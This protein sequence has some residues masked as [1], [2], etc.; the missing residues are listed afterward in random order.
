YTELP[1]AVQHVDAPENGDT[2][3]TKVRN[4]SDKKSKNK[5]IFAVRIAGILIIIALIVFV[6]IYISGTIKANEGK[7]I[8]DSVPLGRDISFIEK[9]AG[10]S[11]LNGES[12][13]YGAVNYIAEY[14]HICESEKS[15][16]VDGIML[17]E[18]AVLLRENS[19]GMVEE[20][21]LYNFSLLKHSWMGSRMAS[22]LETTSVEY[23]MSIKSAE[24]AIGLKPYTILKE[25]KE[26]ISVYVY[27]YHYTDDESSNNCV[28]NFCVEVS[29]VDNQVKNVYDEQLDYLNLILQTNVGGNDN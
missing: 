18:W 7:K 6:I 1:D 12:S 28:M 14:D 2:K 29:D 20:A 13:Q 3:K 17:P 10:T 4:T 15:V 25:S 16:T 23:G 27:R 5:L 8:F 11:F 24:R 21:V 9:E 26:N 22:R 19:S